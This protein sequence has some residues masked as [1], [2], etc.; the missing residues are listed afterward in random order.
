MT[1][2]TW[3]TLPAFNANNF[4]DHFDST[5][6]ARWTAV[7]AAS[8]SLTLT[9]GYLKAI[10]T[11]SGDAAG[12]YLASK[13]DKTKSQIWLMT[14][15]PQSS[16]ASWW[17]FSLINTAGAPIADSGPN[18]NA[19]TLVRAEML[20]AGT[21]GLGLTYYNSAGTKTFWSQ[22]TQAWTT[23]TSFAVGGAADTY[24]VIALELDGPNARWRMLAGGQAAASSG[25]YTF[26]QGLRLFAITDWVTWANT[27]ASANIW[28]CL[29][30]F[31]NN[32]AASTIEHEWVRY[33]E[34]P[35]SGYQ[36]GW[37]NQKDLIGSAS[38]VIRHHWTFDGAF[39]VPEDRTTLALNVG[40]GGTWDSSSVKDPFVVRDGVT[41]YMFYSG[42]DGT[43]FQIGV[44]TATAPA[45][46]APQNG[47][48]T[49]AAANPIIAHAAGGDQQNPA[50]A[51]VVKDVSE[52][53]A[54][55]RWKMLFRASNGTYNQLL[56]AT[57]ADPPH[58]ST[59]T[60]QGVVL[61][62]GGAGSLDEH[63]LAGPGG[64]ALLWY[65]NQWE[66][67]YVATDA[68]GVRNL[69]RAT[70]ADL[71]TWTKDGVIYFTNQANGET[72]LTADLAGRTVTVTSTTGFTADAPVFVDNASDAADNYGQSRVRKVT[73]GTH[74]E[75]YHRL[76]GFTTA[77][78]AIISQ[79]DASRQFY[80][81]LVA[82]NPTSSE[83]WFY[84]YAGQFTDWVGAN[85]NTYCEPVTLLKHSNAAPS[86]ANPAYDFL[87]TFVAMRGYNGDS[88]SLENITLV[89]TPLTRGS[90]PVLYHQRQ[91]QGMS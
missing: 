87:D 59:W 10:R 17:L 40:A 35:A 86:G 18:I 72:T 12:A 14:A 13:L 29:G 55:K 25:V 26:D 42:S 21:Y 67:W 89:T 1:A 19:V 5:L 41:D 23:T 56:L 37:L 45:A 63:G 28:L 6:N 24:F 69:T 61:A 3:P 68:A 88:H 75:L 64:P 60:V 2:S 62:L 50:F 7:T 31:R 51:F 43:N 65:G 82:W 32:Q 91:M 76:D 27:R 46:G 66:C 80:P 4:I 33:A 70:S 83:W 9:D 77:L 30:D 15:N 85:Y 90:I 58:T 81:R 47:P 49:K 38:Y 16:A 39:F 74:L 79:V 20:T 73:D 78:S 53:D 22:A 54:N 44:A 52:A 71:V 36:D 34:I 48:W 11:A 8:G 57:A 84:A